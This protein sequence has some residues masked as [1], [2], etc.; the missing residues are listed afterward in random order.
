MQLEGLKTRFREL[1][2]R[3]GDT[4]QISLNIRVLLIIL[5][6]I[7]VVD[8]IISIF[9]LS[10]LGIIVAVMALVILFVGWTAVAKQ[11]RNMLLIFLCLFVILLIFSLINFVFAI[12]YQFIGMSWKIV[13]ML[14]SGLNA[15]G[16]SFCLFFAFRLYS[17]LAT[18]ENYSYTSTPT[19]DPEDYFSSTGINDTAV[20]LQEQPQRVPSYQGYQQQGYQQ[21]GYQQQAYQQQDAYTGTPYVGQEGSTAQYAYN[22]QQ[23]IPSNSQYP[24]PPPMYPSDSAPVYSDKVY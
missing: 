17:L 18:E 8:G 19:A 23:F 24:P 7:R 10:L 2:S 13:D 4:S 5:A 11:S 6:F 21:Q 14:I 20:E 15:I 1:M 16:E 12:M 9:T 3:P 22:P